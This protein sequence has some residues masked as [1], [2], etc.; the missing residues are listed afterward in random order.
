MLVLVASFQ[1]QWEERVRT[2]MFGTFIK[3]KM[4]H[5]P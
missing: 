4:E 2:G 3:L 5:E 1:A